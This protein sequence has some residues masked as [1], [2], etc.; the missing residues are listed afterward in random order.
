MAETEYL[1]YENL[2]AKKDDIEDFVL[3]G[4]GIQAV[5]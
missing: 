4:K 5:E 2:F 1:I 3:E